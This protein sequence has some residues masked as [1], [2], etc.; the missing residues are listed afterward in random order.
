MKTLV[1]SDLHLNHK[2]YNEKKFRYL[3]NL[4]NQADRVVINGDLWCAFSSNFDQFYNSQWNRLFPLLKSKNCVYIEGNHD[5]RKYIDERINNICDKFC[6]NYLLTTQKYNYHFYHGH[7][8]SIDF[9]KSDLN[10]KI[11]RFFYIEAIPVFIE[12]ILIS[13]VGYKNYSKLGASIFNKIQK[14]NI[15]RKLQKNKNDFIVVG[16]THCFEVTEKENYINTGRIGEGYGSCL[17]IEDESFK[18]IHN[19]FTN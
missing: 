6:G 16:H 17:I 13:L 1:I 4:V 2:N 3:E 10:T 19:K 5:L 18:V 9:E 14:I 12:K 7:G 11:R 8:F 15:Q